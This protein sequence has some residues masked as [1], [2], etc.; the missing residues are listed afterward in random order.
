M[1]VFSCLSCDLPNPRSLYLLLLLILSP[2]A[3]GWE[4]TSLGKGTCLLPL[5]T[6]G[7]KENN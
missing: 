5:K 3:D 7:L 1:E 6:F 2:L 4:N